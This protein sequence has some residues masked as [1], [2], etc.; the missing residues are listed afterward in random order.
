MENNEK[1]P[2][3][4]VTAT[5]DIIISGAT[6]E[7]VLEVAKIM[8]KEEKPFYK[9]PKDLE[10]IDTLKRKLENITKNDFKGKV[11][12]NNYQWKDKEG[13]AVIFPI[14]KYSALGNIK[15]NSLNYFLT[16]PKIKSH[17]KT[18]KVLA[19]ML[20][21]ENAKKKDDEPK[22]AVL[23][24]T[25][26]QIALRL[27]FSE[28]E[29]SEGGGK[30]EGIRKSLISLGNSSYEFS[31]VVI[32]G[33]EYK[34]YGL[35]SPCFVLEPLKDREE[36]IISFTGD[37]ERYLLQEGAQHYQL[38]YKALADRNTDYKKRY[39]F[40]FYSKIQSFSNI[41]GDGTRSEFKNLIGVSK[42]LEDIGIGK[43]TL[44][45]PK[46]SFD[47]LAECI[48]YIAK[49]Y[50]AISG[51]KFFERKKKGRASPVIEPLS[52]ET[53]DYND[54]KRK[55]LAPL[56]LNDVRNALI[57]F[58]YP[59]RKVKEDKEGGEDEV[60]GEREKVNL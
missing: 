51:V 23:R 15:E 26:K 4:G 28:E 47:I 5:G 21:E 34:V 2:K 57:S 24:T 8:E 55:I 45:R 36:W 42:L 11:E 38:S 54:F 44:S 41:K 50:G 48:F 39:L 16:P 12:G 49:E 18:Y 14:E 32:N 46:E 19:S 33:K 27:G 30:F 43:F 13:N 10:K 20:V 7:Q 52:F 1:Q 6:K 9:N 29:I 40:Y 17:E 3:M 58:T 25:L 59:E 37:Y 35:L 56:G 22:Q 60:K 53:W 31:N